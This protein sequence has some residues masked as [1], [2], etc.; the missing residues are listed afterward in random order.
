M[1]TYTII[2]VSAIIGLGFVDLVRYFIIRRNEFCGVERKIKSTVSALIVFSMLLSFLIVAD[3]QKMSVKADDVTTD[4][5]IEETTEEPETEEKVVPIT[6]PKSTYGGLSAEIE[7]MLQSNEVS[8]EENAND[9]ISSAY[10]QDELDDA[11]KTMAPVVLKNCHILY[12]EPMIKYCNVSSLNVREEGD[13]DSNAVDILLLGDSAEVVGSYYTDEGKEWYAINREDGSMAY[14]RASYMQDEKI[15]KIYLGDFLITYYC[16]CAQCC[17]WTAGITKSGTVATA[18]RTIAADP[19][20]PFG[21]KL[22]VD[23]VVY[24]VEDRGGLIKG[25]HLDIFCPDHYNARW[26]HVMHTTEVYQI[27]E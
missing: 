25:Q 18:G 7:K 3:Q 10:T 27:V 23:G 21:T 4:K 26:E 9:T 13:P 11:V 8:W 22:L 15:D 16:P 17:G 14:V 5:I 24:T 20:I 2:W 6:K 1:R 12:D 19:S